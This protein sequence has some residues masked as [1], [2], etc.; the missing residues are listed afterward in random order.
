[1]LNKLGRYSHTAISTT[2]NGDQISPKS[3]SAHPYVNGKML[4]IKG[5]VMYSKMA[6]T[7]QR[8]ILN[9]KNKML[10]SCSSVRNV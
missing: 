10:S 6:Y 5:S 8:K 1:M 9:R 2:L 7:N 3:V 4:K